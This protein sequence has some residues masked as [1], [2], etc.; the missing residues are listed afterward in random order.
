[1]KLLATAHIKG[2]NLFF[3]VNQI[4]YLSTVNDI[5]VDVLHIWLFKVTKYQTQIEETKYTNASISSITYCECNCPH[6]WTGRSP[7]YTHTGWC[8]CCRMSLLHTHY[9]DSMSSSCYSMY[10]WSSLKLTKCVACHK[11]CAYNIDDGSIFR[12]SYSLKKILA[13]M[14]WTLPQYKFTGNNMFTNN[15]RANSLYVFNI[16]YIALC[17]KQS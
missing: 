9:S 11:L 15:C 4:H 14:I 10:R 6:V 17:P 8:Q 5:H 16:S 7:S 3:Q 2:H 1:M 12:Q 13:I